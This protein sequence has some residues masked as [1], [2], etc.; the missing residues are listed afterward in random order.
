MGTFC[1]LIVLQVIAMDTFI[2]LD[3]MKL[4]SRS[5]RIFEL[6]S[7]VYEIFHDLW[8]LYANDYTHT[9][10]FRFSIESFHI[11]IHYF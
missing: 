9:T 4:E 3:A 7:H 5:H 10:L 6:P 8:L 11:L 2:K 1:A